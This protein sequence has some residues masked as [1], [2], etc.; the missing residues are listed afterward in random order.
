MKSI[1]KTRPF[2]V[3]DMVR[4][5]A[6]AA[7]AGLLVAAGATATA[8]AHGTLGKRVEKPAVCLYFAYDEDEVMSF[9]KVAVTAPGSDT[10][11]Q[12]LATDR[13]GIACFAPDAPGDWRVVA[14]DGMG[15]RQLMVVAFAGEER[16]AISSPPQ[17][18][19]ARL[20]KLSG[21]LAGIATIG[22]ATGLVA[23]YRSR[24]RSE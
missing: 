3:F 16:S 14:S 17:S 7:A 12:T 8:H 2:L 10:A 9:V 13:N 15:H 5:V 23:W 6:A 11:F 24:R 18:E 1:I 22:G 19:V 21:V 20:D 4:A